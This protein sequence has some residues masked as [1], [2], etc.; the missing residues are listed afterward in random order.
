MRMLVHTH[1]VTYDEKINQWFPGTPEI[2]I[3]NKGEGDGDKLGNYVK[4]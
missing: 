3:C 2:M 1:L 4:G